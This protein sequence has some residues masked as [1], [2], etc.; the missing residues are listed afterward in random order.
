VKIRW[1]VIAVITL[2]VISVTMAGCGETSGS[3]TKI[4]VVQ[5]NGHILTSRDLGN[6]WIDNK[7]P[8]GISPWVVSASNPDAVWAV[9]TTDTGKSSARIPSG[10]IMR[11]SDSGKSWKTLYSKQGLDFQTIT[12][13]NNEV[14]WAAGGQSQPGIID[15]STSDPV[16]LLTTDAGKTW[17]NTAPGS[18]MVHNV[19]AQSASSSEIDW[20]IA[21]ARQGDFGV[22]RTGDGGKTWTSVFYEKGI[23]PTRIVAS[24]QDS[25]W[26]LAEPQD[27]GSAFEPNLLLKTVDGG[28][29]WNKLKVKVN[30]TQPMMGLA[31]P[32]SEIAWLTGSGED[33]LMTENGGGTW[34]QQV[35][36]TSQPFITISAASRLS[37]CA[38]GMKDVILVTS[39][40]GNIWKKHHAVNRKGL[41]Y[42]V[43]MIQY[44]TKQ[45]SSH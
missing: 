32:T 22:F 19:R 36:D 34:T 18:L 24:T 10:I 43:S 38:I 29:H 12:A 35:T 16:I 28:T 33:I 13:V 42:S 3:Q 41:L 5:E 37:A 14:A 30:S 1:T 39:D 40:G 4:Y 25:A 8:A 21:P 11:S 20:V 45:P 23:V 7:P 31:A 26:C 44:P 9:G 27:I 17:T 6:T 2:L 15:Q